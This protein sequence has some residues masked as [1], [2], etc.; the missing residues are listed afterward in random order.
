[1]LYISYIINT[2]HALYITSINYKF[3][4]SL[5]KSALCDAYF[6]YHAIIIF[7]LQIP[8]RPLFSGCIITPVNFI[9]TFHVL[10]SSTFISYLR[11]SVTHEIYMYQLTSSQMHKMAIKNS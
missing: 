8:Q 2:F 4:V 10:M 11:V 1:M 6:S 9:D 3:F 5:Q 7:P